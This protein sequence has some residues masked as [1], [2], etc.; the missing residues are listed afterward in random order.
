MR[1]EKGS[2][3]P[4]RGAIVQTCV[5]ALL[6]R[7]GSILLAKRAATRAW[8]PDVW[9]LPGGHCESGETCEAALTREL[10]EEI[11]VVPL[12]WVP[13]AVLQGP[14]AAPGDAYVLHVYAVTAWQGTP[15][16]LLPEEHSEVAW[17]AIDDA[18]R[19]ALAH[20]DYPALFRQAAAGCAAP[21]RSTAPLLHGTR[22]RRSRSRP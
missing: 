13:L 4:A 3:S 15:R 7:E 8:F 22:P 17:V 20:P 5:G 2:G 21:A 12:A 1:A 19:L 18:C 10:S 6:I 14:D 9:D 16:N 11:G